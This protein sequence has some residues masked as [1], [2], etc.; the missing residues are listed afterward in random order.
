M[1]NHTQT[2]TDWRRDW[3]NI[4]VGN[5]PCTDSPT[6]VA[7]IQCAMAKKSRVARFMARP[8]PDGVLAAL[9]VVNERCKAYSIFQSRRKQL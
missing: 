3:R 8:L 6:F 5:P 4:R 1:T 7:A 9:S 2:R